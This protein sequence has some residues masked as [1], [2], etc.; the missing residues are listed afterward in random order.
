MY[1]VPVLGRA[2]WVVVDRDDPWVVSEDSPIL[3][4]HPEVVNAFAARLGADPSWTKVFDSA[5]V[6]VFRKDAAS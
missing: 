4:N 2:T 6:V 5:G 3:T 1:S